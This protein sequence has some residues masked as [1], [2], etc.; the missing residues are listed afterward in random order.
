L[1]IPIGLTVT[2]ENDLHLGDRACTV[3]LSSYTGSRK[4]GFTLI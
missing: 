1:Q 4:A 3:G 2:N